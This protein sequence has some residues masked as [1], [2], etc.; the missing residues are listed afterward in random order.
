MIRFAIAFFSYVALSGIYAVQQVASSLGAPK[1]LVRPKNPAPP[2]DEALV[3]DNLTDRIH[4]RGRRLLLRCGDPAIVCFLAIEEL[5]SK[6]FGYVRDVA[7]AR[8]DRVGRLPGR[9]YRQIWYALV[10][11]G[12]ESRVTVRQAKNTRYIF[13]LVRNNPEM[14]NLPQAGK[15]EL[16]TYLDRAY[17]IGEFESIWSVEGLGHV[18]TQRTWSLDWGASTDARGIL[19]DGQAMDLPD[20]SLTMMHAGLGL[21]FAEGLLKQLAPKSSPAEAERVVALFLRLCRANSRPGYVGCALESLGLVTRCFNYPL[22]PQ[23]SAALSKLDRSALEY[24]WRG[25]GRAIYFS[26]AHLLPPLSCP[27]SAAE[28]EAPDGRVLEIMKAGLA[29]PASLVNMR[30]PEIF[31]RFLLRHARDPANERA[32]FHGVA[33]STV[34]AIDI[35]PGSSTVERYVRHEPISRDVRLEDR[36]RRLVR[37]PIEAAV[38][39]YHPLLRRHE[40]IDEI[41]RFQDLEIL[42]QRLEASPATAQFDRT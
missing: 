10:A 31:E 20:K 6:G 3:P 22:V 19:T 35:A 34:M 12:A 4:L 2:G 24:F 18:F 41:F 27:W 39:R 17:E 30:T 26:P 29:W 14:L 16:L 9:V 21:A 23:V 33:A 37:D 36:W 5:L 40:K 32:I 15:L 28:Q 7:A 1:R 25:A 42:T 11:L 13:V 8:F 38:H